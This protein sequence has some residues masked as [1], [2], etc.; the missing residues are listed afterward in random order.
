MPEMIPVGNTIT[1]PNA[2][3]TL[4]QLSG[5][6]GLQQ[7]QLGLQTGQANLAGVQAQSDQEQQK[8]R[9]LKALSTFTQSASKDPSYHN[10]DGSLNV[11]KFQADAARVAPVY[12]QAYIGQ[13]TTNANESIANRQALL[14]LT[15]DQ[16][17]TAGKIFQGFAISGGGPKEWLDMKAQLEG[18]NDD[19]GWH[20]YLDSML[21]HAPNTGALSDD[22]AHMAL[23]Q[24]ARKVAAG[25]GLDVSAGAPT[26]TPYFDKAGK[27]AFYQSNPQAPGGIRTMGPEIPVGLGPTQTPSYQGQVSAAQTRASGVGRIDLD[28][29]SQVSN[30]IQ[31]SNASIGLTQQIDELADQIQSGKLSEE[32]SK[33]AAAVGIQPGTYARQLLEKDLGQLKTQATRYAPSDQAAGTILSGYP[34]ATSDNR[35][36]HTAMDYI[37][38]SMRL[39]IMRGHQLN[40]LQ[41]QDPNVTGFQRADDALTSRFNPLQ[42]EFMSLRTPAERTEFYRRNFKDRASMEAF[43]D[44]IHGAG[45]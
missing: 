3:Q 45:P 9:E 20:R 6:L 18:L 21:Q 17:A 32:I 38:G 26:A 7:Q 12:G 25:S 30:L 16:Q 8:N 2:G 13:M 29:A 10:A 34:E 43:R 23:Q 24:Y 28:R 33:A 41:K 15:N 42:A 27:Q 35:T 1:P 5:I 14:K 22:Q 44:S 4:S 11:Q 19:P 40:E 37:R 31:P 36:I 39:N